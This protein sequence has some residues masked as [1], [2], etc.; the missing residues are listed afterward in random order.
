[1]TPESINHTDIRSFTEEELAE[2]LSEIGAKKFRASQIYRWLHARCALAY[3][4]MTDLPKG[5]REKLEELYPLD[6]LAVEEK[7]VSE[8]D[9][10]T[11]YLIRLADGNSVECVLMFYHHG[12]S[13]CISSQVGCN[14]GCSFCASTIGGKVRNLTAGEMLGQIYRMQRDLEEAGS[15]QRDSAQRISHVVVMGTGEPLDNY[16]S[17]IGFIRMI[18]DEK[19]RNISQRNLTV[20]TCGIVPNM[21]KLADE[22]FQ[23]T[24][25]LS[26]HASSQE[27]REK[28]M[29]VARTWHLPDIFEACEEYFQKTGRRITFEYTMV[30][31]QN[32]SDEDAKRLIGLL[33]GKN[34]HINLIP[35]NPVR[36]RSYSAPEKAKAAR[37]RDLLIRGGI[38][39]TIRRSMGRDIDGACGQLRRRREE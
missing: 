18:S 24:L 37:F 13:A 15:N 19:G 4:E 8:I 9:G 26:L 3:D 11:K 17:L 25:A 7:Q 10:T 6:P 2:K 21:R 20:S 34:C 16:D 28:L 5:L 12:V 23:I 39:A 30:D 36:E 22:G 38:N 14:M 1:M 27:S 35:L 32:I 33:R 29:P 31:G